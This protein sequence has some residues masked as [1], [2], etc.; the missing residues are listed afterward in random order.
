M[1]QI[2]RR[3]DDLS[4][5]DQLQQKQQHHSF[6]SRGAVSP[7]K[8]ILL[9]ITKIKKIDEKQKGSM[10]FHYSRPHLRVCPGPA[11]ES[12]APAVDHGLLKRS[13]I[14]TLIYIHQ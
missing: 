4:F 7:L 8:L 12:D 5:F 1:D 10:N 6:N 2:N 3:I 11:A 13:P 14:V 9:K